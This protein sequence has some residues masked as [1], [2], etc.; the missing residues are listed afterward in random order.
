M[1][2]EVYDGLST[3]SDGMSLSVDPSLLK[4]S[5]CAKGLNVSMRGGKAHTRG[6]WK[7]LAATLPNGTFQ[8]AGV[9]RLNGLDRIV[10]G[11]YGS[12]Y[13][14]NMNTFAVTNHG[15]LLSN[16]VDR[17]YFT[18]AERYMVVQDGYAPSTWA[19]A[20]WPVI[21]YEDGLF[22]QS[23]LPDHERVPKGAMM[24]YGHGRL[25]VAA[26]YVYQSGAFTGNLGRVGF[27]AGDIIKSYNP[28]SVLDFKETNYLAEGGRII[29]TE[30]LGYIHGMGFQKNVMT[31]GVGQGPLIVG[32]EY[33]FSAYGVNAPRGQWKDIDL[34]VVLFSG[35]GLGT[36]SPQSWVTVNSE[37]F[38]RSED[39]IR[40][41]RQSVTEAQGAGL[42]SVPVSA[43]VNPLIDSDTES[44]R[45]RVSAAMHKRRMMITA[46][47]DGRQ[48]LGLIS[49]D[50]E[51][52]ANVG[53]V[54]RPVYDGVWTG[55]KINQVVSSRING[56]DKLVAF[57]KEGAN[58][59]AMYVLD[60]DEVYDEGT[61][62]PLCRLYTR[63][64]SS[65]AGP[66]VR[67]KVQN[68][69]AWFSDVLGEVTATMYFRCHGHPY[70]TKMSTA[71]FNADP[72]GPGQRR[73]WVTFTK[74]TDLA[75]DVSDGNLLDS[76]EEIQYCVEWR[77]HCKLEKIRFKSTIDTAEDMNIAADV[78]ED[79][80]EIVPGDN[81]Y[82]L[83][84]DEYLI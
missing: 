53:Q 5:Q 27:L 13:A 74:P 57:V 65:N 82:D 12:V 73:S 70:W 47:P 40:G 61:K 67:K 19:A 84:D 16:S 45:A 78:Q 28:S 64:Y 37:I 9:Y 32:A 24:A 15:S 35:Q 79:E 50:T 30:E 8:G 66:F 62:K 31:S 6:R 55:L 48:F 68:V 34:G 10:I 63:A 23:A 26:N 44:Q 18:Q 14:S 71:T 4:E 1:A 59:N 2:K 11:I 25:F 29:L 46:V 56:E 69:T 75:A 58:G 17:F 41:L 21:I 54:S 76:A 83:D 80:L 22:D 52:V 72:D 43:E 77:G 49:L 51:P 36:N 20:N 3:L 60:D 38:Y 33:G 42:Q 39:G 7:K 81:E